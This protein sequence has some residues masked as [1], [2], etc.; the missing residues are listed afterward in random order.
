MEKISMNDIRKKNYSDVYRLIYQ[1]RRISKSKIASSLEMS[2]P[3]VTQHLSTLEAEGLIEKQGQMASGIG[4]K[5]AAYSIK[6]EAR[7]SIGLEILPDHITAVI[8]NL[9]GAIIGKKETL[10]PFSMKAEYFTALRDMVGELLQHSSIANEAVLGVGIG[11]QGL[12]SE[13]GQRM[14]YGKILDCTGLTIHAL[15]DLL[16][17]PV[18]FIHDAECAAELELWRNPKLTDVIY[19]S[20]GVH[21][22]GAIIMRGQ[23]QRGRTGRTGTVEHM[24]LVEG[25]RPCYCGKLGCMECYC[26]IDAILEDGEDLADFFS[27]LR[28]GDSW[29]AQRWADYLD[30]L[31]IALNNLHMVLDCTIV[32]GGHLAPYLIKQDIDVLFSK[33]QDRTAFPE[34]ENFICIGTQEANTVASGAAIPF[35]RA[36]LDTI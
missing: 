9:H 4:R 17:Y 13:D 35:I 27:R 5:A 24:T 10:L 22:G 21:L 28:Q 23:I 2:L 20:L 29:R 16:P 3:T 19:L 15:S 12:V 6:P 30:Y 8:L 31:A 26:S 7:V 25:G 33:L 18:R 36:F 34:E 1:E 11:M 14:L 32:L